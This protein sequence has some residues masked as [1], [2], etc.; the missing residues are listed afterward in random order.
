M[1][2]TLLCCIILRQNR[3]MREGLMALSDPA[4]SRNIEKKFCCTPLKKGLNRVW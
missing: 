3:E 2:L 1:N 4:P